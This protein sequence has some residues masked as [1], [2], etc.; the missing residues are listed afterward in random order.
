MSST[1]QLAMTFSQPQ[2]RVITTAQ[3]RELGISRSW[4]SRQAQTGLF[5]R[6]HRGVFLTHS[7][8]IPWL[9]QAHAALLI[10]GP[11]SFL[12]H[13]SAWYLAGMQSSA[14]RRITVSI[15]AK[16]VLRPRTGITYFRRSDEP[17]VAGTPKYSVPEETVLD[18]IARSNNKIDIVGLLSTAV[19]ENVRADDIMRALKLRGSFPRAQLVKSLLGEIEDGVESPLE[20]L[21]DQDVETAHGL[22]K[23]TKQHVELIDGRW[24]RADRIFRGLWVRVELD[25][26]LAHPGGRTNSDT[27]RDNAVMIKHRDITLRYRWHHVIG[28]PCETAGQIAAALRSRGW[29]GQPRNCGPR[30]RAGAY[31]R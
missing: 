21:Y 6:L 20:H 10:A 31:L 15:P 30:C 2:G 5:K 7:A 11:Q 13:E 18:I 16:R 27:W 26:Q 3:A 4:L 9:S 17:E 19:R 12:S 1:H 8:T 23:S 22:P 28:Q 29:P 24:I 25:G 14:P